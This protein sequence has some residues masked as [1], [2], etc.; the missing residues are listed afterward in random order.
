MKGIVIGVD[1]EKR[2]A[3]IRE[4][5]TTQ[6]CVAKWDR[7]MNCNPKQLDWRD[8]VSYQLFSQSRG[9]TVREATNIC[10][11]TG[12]DAGR[13]CRTESDMRMKDGK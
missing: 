8:V 4:I 1:A 5:G 10:I 7:V 9:S 2:T 12:R 13:A 6:L 3:I 11:L